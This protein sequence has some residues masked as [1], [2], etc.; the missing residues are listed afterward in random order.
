ME[1][2]VDDLRG[3]S[4]RLRR[5]FVLGKVRLGNSNVLRTGRGTTSATPDCSGVMK[6]D[7]GDSRGLN[8]RSQS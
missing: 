3:P 8:G 2:D 6:G 4:M 7:G 1:V 5:H